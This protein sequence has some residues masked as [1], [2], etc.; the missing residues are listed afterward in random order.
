MLVVQ[1]A[2]IR[3][4]IRW[5]IVFFRFPTDSEWYVQQFVTFSMVFVT[6]PKIY[7]GE[8]TREQTGNSNIGLITYTFRACQVLGSQVSV[9]LATYVTAF[10]RH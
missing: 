8:K 2:L 6:P 10:L 3:I 1:R 5:G 9:I 7:C 4:I